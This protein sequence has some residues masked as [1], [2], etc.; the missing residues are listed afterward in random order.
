MLF[1]TFLTFFLSFLG[2][3][4]NSLHSNIKFSVEVESGGGLSSWM[5]LLTVIGNGSVGHRVYR[6]ST[7][8][9]LYSSTGPEEDGSGTGYSYIEHK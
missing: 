1:T 2:M 7:H 3:F 8:T 6:K 9:D 5:C 4:L